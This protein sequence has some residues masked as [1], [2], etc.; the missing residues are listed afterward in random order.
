M[1]IA[2]VLGPFHA[3]PPTG[4]GAVERVWYDLA[5]AFAHRGHAVQLLGKGRAPVG[6]GPL[7]IVGMRGFTA[8]GHLALDLLKDF[9]YGVTVALRIGRADVVVSNSFWIPVILPLLRPGMAPIVVHVARFP[10]HQMMLY[11]R[12]AA[13]QAIS[14]AV[15]AEVRR[16]SPGLSAR[17]TVLP[18]PVDLHCF[19]PPQAPRHRDGVQTLLYLGRVHPEK[20]VHVLIDAV[21]RLIERGRAVRL[22]IVGPVAAANGGG[23]SRYRN[24][25]ERQAAGLPVEF[26]AALHDPAAVAAEYRAAHCFCYPSLAVRGEAFGLAPLEAMATGLPVVVSALACFRDYVE[27][28]RNG[29]VFDHTARAPDAAL[30]AALDRLLGDAQFAACLGA[31]ARSTAERF[32][33]ASI[34]DDYLQLLQRVSRR[35]SAPQL[36]HAR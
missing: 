34:T 21:R 29:L 6:R 33:I 10:K 19:A 25:L 12:A 16:Q 4:C 5:R 18:Y 26:G 31:R 3:L 7:D 2:I 36:P 27:D 30:A 13:L 8:T 20:G 24:A 35:P 9:L 23:G 15:A 28:G 32:G 11:R 22:R 17:V 14:S 1:N